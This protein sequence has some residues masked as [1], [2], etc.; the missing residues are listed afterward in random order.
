MEALALELTESIAT[1]MKTRFHQK[2]N[3]LEASAFIPPDWDINLL[4]ECDVAVD[5]LQQAYKNKS[6]SKYLNI[7]C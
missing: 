6:R 1:Y 4:Y 7:V 5:I 3:G 2:I